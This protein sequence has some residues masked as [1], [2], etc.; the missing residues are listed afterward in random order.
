MRGSHGEQLDRVHRRL[1]QL[2]DRVRDRTK[3]LGALSAGRRRHRLHRRLERR[4][5]RLA[6]QHRAEEPD[7]PLRC[8]RS[9]VREAY[10]LRFV[11]CYGARRRLREGAVAVSRAAAAAARTARAAPLAPYRACARWT[12]AQEATAR[13]GACRSTARG[14]ARDGAR[15]AAAGC[16]IERTR[17]AA[18]AAAAILPWLLERLADDAARHAHHSAIRRAR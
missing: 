5:R 7:R 16:A 15:P 12:A 11:K 6:T 2:V 13:D 4:D 8:A 1:A 9:G 14:G 17:G 18:T 3:Q 10:G